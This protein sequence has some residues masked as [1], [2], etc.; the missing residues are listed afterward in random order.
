MSSRRSWL[1]PFRTLSLETARN[2]SRSELSRKLAAQFF[3][4]RPRLEHL[5]ERIVLDAVGWNVATSGNWN[6]SANWLDS[7]TGQAKVPSS[8]D[9]V[10][11]NQSGVTVTVS[12]AEN[13][14]SLTTAGGANLAVTAGSLTLVNAATLNGGFDLSGGKVTIDTSL[15]LAGAS[16]WSGGTIEN[17]GGLT[18][19]GTITLAGSQNL[20][21][22][23]GLFDN[24]GTIIQS[25]GQFSLDPDTTLLNEAGGVYDLEVDATLGA[26]RRGGGAKPVLVNAGTFKKACRGKKHVD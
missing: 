15:T 18:N 13:A 14:G 17:D 9:Q 23:P 25:S 19:Q 2:R 5:E 12:D 7:T 20:T 16:T 8:T 4:L 10:T 1:R 22:G 3:R 26:S 24:A 11:I 21:F 6:V